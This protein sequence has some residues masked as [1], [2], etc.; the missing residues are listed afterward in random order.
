MNL[1]SKVHELIENFLRERKDLFLVDLKVSIDNRIQVYIDGD[2]SV[3]IQDCLDLS[4]AIEFNL[5]REEEDF[6]LDVSSYGVVEPLKMA[7]Q[8][9]KNIGRELKI[10]TEEKEYKGILAQVNDE[11]IVIEWK[12]RQPKKVGKGKETVQLEKTIPINS[13]NKAQIVLKF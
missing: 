8:Y 4:R 7:R 12:E 11:N 13:I 1:E 9:A 6:S 5:D 10:K 3:S 2:S